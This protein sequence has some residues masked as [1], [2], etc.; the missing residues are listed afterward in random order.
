[1]VYVLDKRKKPLMPCS[2]KRAR[3]LL[4]RGRAVVHKLAPFT[5]RLRDRLVEDSVLQ[6]LDLKLDPGSKVTGGAVVRDC[7]E[8]IGCYECSHRTDIKANLD[9]RR[10]QR[11]SRRNRKTRYRKPRGSSWDWRSI[12]ECPNRNNVA[13]SLGD[14]GRLGLVIAP[15]RAFSPKSRDCRR[16]ASSS[17]GF[18]SGVYDPLRPA[19]GARSSFCSHRPSSFH[20]EP[21]HHARFRHLAHDQHDVPEAVL[22]LAWNFKSSSILPLARISCTP[23]FSRLAR[24]PGDDRHLRGRL[25]N[26]RRPGP[27]NRKYPAGPIPGRPPSE[28]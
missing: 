21:G 24:A 18:S 11:S 17:P 12:P 27:G 5:I 22:V 4:E 13:C 19:F 1:M 16:R 20:R 14:P 15:L 8:T 6:P 23:D 10:S 2:E 7:K 26:R 3:L 28:G 25:F 9:A